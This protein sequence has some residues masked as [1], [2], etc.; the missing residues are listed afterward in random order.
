M[1]VKGGIPREVEE[2]PDQF[3]GFGDCNFAT[4]SKA[5]Y[6]VYLHNII[7]EDLRLL[8]VALCT[9]QPLQSK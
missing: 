5:T 9:L 1:S 7:E 3:I 2:V 8:K 4:H 6:R